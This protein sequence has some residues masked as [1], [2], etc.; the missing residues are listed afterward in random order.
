M[1]A[2]GSK[3]KG[4]KSSGEFKQLLQKQLQDL[5]EGAQAETLREAEL[6]R[7]VKVVADSDF[8]W[9]EDYYNSDGTKKVNTT[10]GYTV[11][12]FTQDTEP[13]KEDNSYYG[14]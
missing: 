10:S 2:L 9:E 5:L 12:F 8:K 4:G 13:G 3:V 7:R 1:S 14:A 11:T 6:T